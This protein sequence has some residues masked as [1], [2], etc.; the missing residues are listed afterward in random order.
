MAQRRAQRER[1]LLDRQAVYPDLALLAH[2]SFA[3]LAY[4]HSIQALALSMLGLLLHCGGATVHDQNQL[5]E[6][7]LT[8][9]VHVAQSA[10]RNFLGKF[11]SHGDNVC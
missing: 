10:Q 9:A 6:K 3:P 1:G 4:A 7:S 5:P 11:C 8:L 2:P